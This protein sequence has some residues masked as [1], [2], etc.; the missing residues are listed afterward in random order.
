MSGPDTITEF[1]EE[2][3]KGE[4]YPGAVLLV[5]QAGKIL[6]FQV[7][8]IR[9]LTPK[10]MPMGRDTIFDLASLTKP[11]ATSL[12]VMKLVESG[13]VDLDQPLQDLLPVIVPKDKRTVTP[14]FLLCHSAGFAE[15]KP[16]YLELQ[17]LRTHERKPA[18]RERLL[19]LPLIY[20]PGKGV[21]Y[22]DLGYMMLEWVIEST[23]G[24]AMALFLN[25]HFYGPLSLKKTFFSSVPR[26][27][28]LPEDQFAA[29]EKC[30]WRQRVVVGE[31]HDENAYALGGY[32]GQA[33]LFGVA[34]EVWILVELLRAHFKGERED[35][36]TPQTVRTFFSR[37][38]RVR[39]STWA[40]GWDTPS[41]DG[42]S[43][44]RYFSESS[45]GHL[46][47][48]GTSVWMDL[49]RDL[50]VVFLTNR[51]HPTRENEKIKDFRPALHDRIA[52][53]LGI[54]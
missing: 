45:V 1:L 10:G 46:G 36:L 51:V 26:P 5:S 3:V 20:P 47:F 52:R 32:S 39:E 29:T 27:P 12:A 49:D 42:S 22:S 21:M 23:A 53:E 13:S 9:S 54:C 48:T 4:V 6:F 41:P 24:M 11:L 14:R 25:Q 44:G 50:I 15:W 40:L 35:V 17:N 43:S 33:G 7:A 38:D 28:T 2:G 31:V 18:L 34:R 19:S 16:F 8:G 30:P 37:Q